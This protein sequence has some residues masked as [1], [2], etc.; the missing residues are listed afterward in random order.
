MAFFELS[1][2]SSPGPDGFKEAF[3][4]AAWEFIKEDVTNAV[5]FFFSTSLIPAGLISNIVT[6]IPKI[7][8]ASRVEDF[9]PVVL[10]NFLFKI[11]TKIITGHLGPMLRGL[12]SSLQYRFILGKSIHQFIPASSEGFQCL[13]E[14]EGNMALKIDIRKVFDTM[15]W[16]FIAQVLQCIGFSSHFCMMIDSI[17]HSARLSISF[18]GGLEG[19][20][21][22]SR[23][24]R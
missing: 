22:C 19:V 2:D 21:G 14:G 16:D 7:V 1:P 9:S 3:F 15:N 10:E 20:F 13:S 6:L 5:G 12:L 11:L 18:N 24:V 4:Q 17:L 8:G 23:G